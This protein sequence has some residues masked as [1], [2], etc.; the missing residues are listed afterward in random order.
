MKFKDDFQ[1][2][3][4][5]ENSK[6]V[7][8]PNEQ[9]DKAI[10]VFNYLGKLI[11]EQILPTIRV[12]CKHLVPVVTKTS[13]TILEAYPNKRVV[14]LAMHGKKRTRKKNIN[15]IMKDLRGGK[16]NWLKRK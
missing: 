3:Y 12:L 6:P 11:Q 10:K 16:V 14:Y 5:A 7:P 1:E 15:R 9:I 8:P 4:S 2:P 13:Q